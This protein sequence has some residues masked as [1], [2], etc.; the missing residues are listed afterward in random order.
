MENKILLVEANQLTSNILKLALR[1]FGYFVDVANTEEKA[2][3]L[4]KKGEYFAIL[5][6]V[7]IPGI[8]GYK[9]CQKIKEVKKKSKLIAMTGYDA[10]YGSEKCINAGFNN[11]FPKPLD[12]LDLIRISRDA[13]ERKSI[14]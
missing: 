9:I 10:I 3:E 5:V 13:I 7:K 1:D 4:G 14:W 11:F 8:D 12:T 2:L 6:N